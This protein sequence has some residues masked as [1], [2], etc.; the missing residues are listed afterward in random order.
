M[1]EDHSGL[2]PWEFAEQLRKVHGM[3]DSDVA[4]EVLDILAVNILGSLPPNHRSVLDR[5]P[6]I[7]LPTRQP[8]AMCIAVPGGGAVIAVDYGL[9]SFLNVLNKAV[10]CRLNRFG[11]EPTMSQPEAINAVQKAMDHFFGAKEELPRWPVSPKRMLVA[12]ALSNVQVSFVV[13][14]EIGHVLLGHLDDRTRAP[15]MES[16]DIGAEVHSFSDL[17]SMEFAA[18]LDSARRTMSHFSKVYDPLFGANE[19]SYSQAGVD[20]F[21]SYLE[22]LDSRMGLSGESST[23]PPSKVRREE[24]RK[25]MWSTLPEPSRELA[26]CFDTI[27]PALPEHDGMGGQGRKP[28]DRTGH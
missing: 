28:E 20:I 14:H 27:I 17:H 15:V 22:L 24:L 9:M 5:F 6:V 10:L 26:D 18:D 7:V 25:A 16:K 19:P 4:A 2:T 8:N 13:G 11:M 12:S 21:F 1:S 3:G 23:H